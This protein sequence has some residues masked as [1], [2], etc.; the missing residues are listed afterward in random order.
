[1]KTF[2]LIVV[3]AI[4]LG[5]TGMT[6]VQSNF[7]LGEPGWMLVFG[8]GLTVVARAARRRLTGRSSH[9]G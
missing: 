3:V 5:L 2:G 6:I 1:M 7:R 4:L 9:S 8:I